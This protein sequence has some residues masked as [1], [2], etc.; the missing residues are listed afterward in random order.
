MSNSS[1]RDDLGQFSVEHRARRLGIRKAPEK[2]PLPRRLI[3]RVLVLLAGV[4]VMVLL[5][6]PF[7]DVPNTDYPEAQAQAAQSVALHQDQQAHGI[8][9]WPLSAGRK[10]QLSISE[11][12][13]KGRVVTVDKIEF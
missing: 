13:A 5:L 4:V 2:P 12:V 1:H 6:V 11:D 8:V 10:V 3:V 9:W 7:G